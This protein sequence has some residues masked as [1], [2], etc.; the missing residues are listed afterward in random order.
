MRMKMKTNVSLFL[1]SFIFFTS[2]CGFTSCKKKEED[3]INYKVKKEDFFFSTNNGKK[4]GNGRIEFP[5]GDSVYMKLVVY[6]QSSDGEEHDISGELMIPNIQAVDS[7]YVKGQKITPEEDEVNETTTYPFEI[8]TDEEWTFIFEFIPNETGKL[9]MELSF[10][11]SIA[12]KYDMTNTIKIVE[13][14]DLDDDEDEIDE[15]DEDDEDDDLDE[16]SKKGK[17]AHEKV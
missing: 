5:V 10:D 12:E 16:E 8:T 9:T 2:A 7:Y 17:F 15:D 1:A 13:K 4:Y 14:D 11:D 6:I 3:K